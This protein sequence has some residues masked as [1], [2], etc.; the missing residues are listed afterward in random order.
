MFPDKPGGIT[1][2]ARESRFLSPAEAGYGGRTEQLIGLAVLVLPLFLWAYRRV[3]RDKLPL[4]LTAVIA[5][6]ADPAT[7]A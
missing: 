7:K 6:D 5:P 2:F 4:S 3:V 1:M